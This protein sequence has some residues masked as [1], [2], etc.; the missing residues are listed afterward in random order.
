[1]LDRILYRADAIVTGYAPVMDV[2]E[3]IRLSRR[4]RQVLCRAVGRRAVALATAVPGGALPEGGAPY[5]VDLYEALA[6]RVLPPWNGS[7]RP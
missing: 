4:E 5:V 2:R 1:M 3:G 6:D 7:G